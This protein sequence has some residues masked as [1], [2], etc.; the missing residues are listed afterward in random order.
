MNLAQEAFIKP[1]PSLRSFKGGPV[2][3]PGLPHRW[4]QDIN[5]LKQRKNR[6]Q[7][8]LDTFDFNAEARIAD[9][10]ALVSEKTRAV[11]WSG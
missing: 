10:V 3:T 4:Q 5:F 2:S 7:M 1:F 8:S 6:T 11:G 9:L